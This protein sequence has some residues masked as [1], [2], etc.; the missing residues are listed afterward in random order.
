MAGEVQELQRLGA[1][2]RLARE[3]VEGRRA[4]LG[5]Y[6]LVWWEGPAA[7][8]YQG[9]VEGRR[10]ALQRLADELEWLAAAVDALTEAAHAEAG[11]LPAVPEAS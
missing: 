1:R 10:A 9:L 3:S 8:R 7:D 2:L 6:A 11:P 4:A 5:R